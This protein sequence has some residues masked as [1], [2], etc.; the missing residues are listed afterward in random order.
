MQ[1]HFPSKEELIDFIQS[2]DLPPKK[3]E[4]C[5]AFHIKGN[6]PRM[7]LKKCLYELKKEGIYSPTPFSRQHCRGVF[8]IKRIEEEGGMWAR[9]V[10][11]QH[12]KQCLTIEPEVKVKPSRLVSDTLLTEGATFFGE[13]P[14]NTQVS[15]IKILHAEKLE[16]SAL[17]GVV[18]HQ[19]GENLFFSTDKKYRSPFQIKGKET[20]QYVGQFVQANFVPEEKEWVTIQKVLGSSKEIT[21]FVIEQHNLPRQFSD[22][23]VHSIKDACVPNLGNRRDLRDIPLVTIDGKDSRDFDDAVWAAPDTHP[24]NKGGWRII[25]AIADVSHYVKPG[26]A[27][28]QEAYTRGNSVYFPDKVLPML[29]EKLSND[30]CSLRPYE[31]RACVGVEIWID[32]D[33]HKQKDKFFRG[34]MRSAKRLTYEEVE[35]VLQARASD[36]SPPILEGVKNLGL[37]YAALKKARAKRGPLAIVSSEVTID[38]DP[39]GTVLALANRP[40]LE[41]HTL[42]EEFMVLANQCAAALLKKHHKLAVYRVHEK[43]EMEKIQQWKDLLKS[44]GIKTKGSFQKAID[45]N[46]V[47]SSIKG[48]TP[49]ILYDMALRT[50]SK[51]V[52]GTEPLGHY[53]LN[54]QDYCHFTSPIRRYA[55]L[56]VHRAIVEVLEGK[57]HKKTHKEKK[58]M[59]E[60]GA[61]ISERERRTM[62]AEREVTDRFATAFY[63]DKIGEEAEGYISGISRAGLFVTLHQCNVSGLLP[64]EA[65]TDDYYME[66]QHPQRLVGRRSHKTYALG[67]PIK[68]IIA[69]A[70]PALGRLTFSL[71]ASFASA[72]SSR[73]PQ[74][75]R[76]K[77]HKTVKKK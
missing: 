63:T 34:L 2:F 74:K 32:A 31:D 25:V 48:D 44:M 40:Q 65:L 29:P 52:Y 36:L 22:E 64:M 51:A 18:L 19:K 10:K 66:R 61:H 68:V 1:D 43:P 72:P 6:E 23:I 8:V 49:P 73:P 76:S 12:S 69:S 4:I 3:R 30:L 45:F 42:I 16:T 71:P 35:E 46:K 56:L 58:K 59:E 75:P 41:S 67:Q 20:Q 33:G 50:Q 38:L 37:A 62:M 11:S 28:D 13:C 54:L 70:D 17:V 39:N 55:D 9:L 53:G 27:L 26:D 14:T 5:N 15:P 57:D 77:R 24:Q 60:V 47:F 7:A 21:D